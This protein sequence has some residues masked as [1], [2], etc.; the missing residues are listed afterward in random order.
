MARNIKAFVGA[1]MCIGGTQICDTFY[2]DLDGGSIVR[3]L[4]LEEEPVETVDVR[5]CFIAP[6]FLELQTNGCLG[7]HFT[8]YKD[9]RRYQENLRNISS[10][11]VS[12]GV[13][14]FYVT[15]PTVTSEVFKKVFLLVFFSSLGL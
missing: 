14:S 3:D 5:G 7:V 9:S 1:S 15:L 11:L 2:I 6:S 13:G 12:Q 8:N 10:H 4:G